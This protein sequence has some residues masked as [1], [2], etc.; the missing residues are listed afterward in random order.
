MWEEVD[1]STA[2]AL[3]DVD[4]EF[5]KKEEMLAALHKARLPL[6]G[7]RTPFAQPPAEML[8]HTA[9]KCG[10][11]LQTCLDSLKLDLEALIGTHDDSVASLDESG[12]P[13]DR[14]VLSDLRRLELLILTLSLDAG[15][16]LHN[17]QLHLVR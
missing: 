17:L 16:R 15:V 5:R 2:D 3:R 14:F 10:L 8:R 4:A 12:H 13:D 11:N 6:A 7:L 9:R 1:P